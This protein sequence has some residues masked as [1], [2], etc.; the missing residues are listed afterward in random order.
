MLDYTRPIR[1]KGTHEKVEILRT[2]LDGPWPVIAVLTADDGRQWGGSF[3]SDDP[4]W[5]NVPTPK[6]SGTV[7]L[8]VYEGGCG[9]V[10]LDRESADKYG[11]S[12]RLASVEV[13]WTE[14][15]GL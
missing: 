10:H 14:G 15:E 1:V 6:R 3:T 4:D 9:A 5:E 11:T 13:K 2:D 7:W 12:N 8:N